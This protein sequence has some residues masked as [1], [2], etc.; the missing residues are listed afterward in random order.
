MDY[1]DI[2]RRRE[3]GIR[4]EGKKKG[5]SREGGTELRDKLLNCIIVNII[6]F[7]KHSKTFLGF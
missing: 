4:R 2:G 5:G 3:R 6:E 7:N 1:A